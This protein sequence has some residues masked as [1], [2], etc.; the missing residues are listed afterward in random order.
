MKPRV[1]TLVADVDAAMRALGSYQGG[2]I[3][4]LGLGTGLGSATASDGSV[5]PL[6]LAHLPYRHGRSYEE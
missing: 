3:L 2:K 4:F 1:P 6:E 5:I